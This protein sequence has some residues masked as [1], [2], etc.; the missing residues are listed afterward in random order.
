[1]IF[2]ALNSLYDQAFSRKVKQANDGNKTITDTKGSR[3]TLAI[4]LLIV[5]LLIGLA[6]SYLIARSI[7]RNVQAVLETI[8]TLRD[9]SATALEGALTAMAGGDMTRKLEPANLQIEKPSNDEIGDVARATNTISDKFASMIE[10]YNT[11]RDALADLIG[12]VAGTA[13]TV[14]SASQ[15]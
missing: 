5:S 2:T 11:S 8:G 10:S 7:R 14:S 13:G 3:T 9:D 6:I 4:V 15:Q 1:P 12:Q